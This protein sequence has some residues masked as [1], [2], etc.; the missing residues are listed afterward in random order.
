MRAGHFFAPSHLPSACFVAPSHTVLCIER[1]VYRL[2]GWEME[3]KT[4][5]PSQQ[6]AVESKQTLS[7][8]VSARATPEPAQLLLTKQDPRTST[9]STLKK[10]TG[11][12][13]SPSLPNASRY[14]RYVPHNTIPLHL[15]PSFA[16]AR[17]DIIHNKS[18]F[19]VERRK[20][21]Q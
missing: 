6:Q 14:E 3:V 10:S 15:F 18:V 9:S 21:S 4:M 19:R 7:P 12:R 20:G 17:F 1:A 13:H 2:V 16:I 11:L 8:A 5:F